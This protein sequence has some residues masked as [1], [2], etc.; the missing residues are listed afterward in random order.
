MACY[1][2]AL[3]LTGKVVPSDLENLCGRGLLNTLPSKRSEINQAKASLP[4][5]EPNSFNTIEDVVKNLDRNNYIQEKKR[6]QGEYTI[7]VVHGTP[8]VTGKDMDSMVNRL[9]ENY[10]AQ[11]TRLKEGHEEDLNKVQDNNHRMQHSM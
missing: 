4:T 6:R 5:S 8:G 3:T 11:M 2:W 10:Q 9:E 1:K 7:G